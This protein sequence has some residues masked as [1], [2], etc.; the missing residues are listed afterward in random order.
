MSADG[1]WNLVIDTPMG[2]QNASIVLT[3]AG[4]TLTGTITD[5]FGQV[6]ITDGV[7]AG[8]QLSWS[9]KMT[10]P[11]PMTLGFTGTIDGDEMTG[12]LK[13]GMFGTSPVHGRRCVE[14]SRDVL[15]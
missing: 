14:G 12:S 4:N 13:A 3:A 8:N 7:V 9:Q 15:A 5:S 11:F 2:K 10:K 6:D 1:T